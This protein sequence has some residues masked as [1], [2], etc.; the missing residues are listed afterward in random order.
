MSVQLYV[1]K[2]PGGEALMNKEQ[3][4]AKAEKK[5][6]K[7]LGEYNPSSAPVDP[8]KEDEEADDTGSEEVEENELLKKL[9]GI[10]SNTDLADFIEN[11]EID[12]DPAEYDGFKAIKAAVAEKL[13]E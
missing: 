3:A 8:K 13:S 12:V 1:V 2:G 4:E 9:K 10:K 6:Y 7:I 5:G 11:N